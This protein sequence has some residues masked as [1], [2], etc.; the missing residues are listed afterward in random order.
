VERLRGPEHN[1]KRVGAFTFCWGAWCAAHASAQGVQLD[2]LCNFHPSLRCEG[3]F[4]GS[5]VKLGGSVRCPTLLCAAGDDPDNVKPGGEIE[6]ALRD[7]PFGD[8]CVLRAFP[9]MKHGFCNRGELSDA[10]VARDVDIVVELGFSMLCSQL[11]ANNPDCKCT[12]ANKK[13]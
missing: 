2:C 3:F 8:L 9:E 5:D 13:R 1:N 10:A 7:K 12:C 6:K 4:G 11:C